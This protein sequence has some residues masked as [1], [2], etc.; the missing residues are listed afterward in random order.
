MA[1]RRGFE[2]RTSWLTA[3]RSAHCA[4]GEVNWTRRSDC[5]L[6]SAF[7]PLLRNVLAGRP[8]RANGCGHSPTALQAAAFD[9]LAASRSGA[10]GTSCTTRTCDLR[11][12]RPALCVPAELTRLVIAGAERGFAR[13]ARPSARDFVASNA[14]GVER[15]PD[16]RAFNA[17]LYLLSYLGNAVWRPVRESNPR[18]PARQAGTLAAELTRRWWLVEVTGFEPAACRLQGG[19]SAVH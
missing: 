19:C 5:S 10:V 2:P 9:H 7:G 16:A 17:P 13:F 4:I 6:R 15:S 18:L 11:L 12:R 3:R 8:A 14:C 1:P